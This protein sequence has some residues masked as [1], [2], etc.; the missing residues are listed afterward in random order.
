MSETKKYNW[1]NFVSFCLMAFLSGATIGISGT[2]FLL[3]NNLYGAWGRLIGGALFSLGIFFIVTYEKKLFTGMVA[4]LPRMKRNELWK[5]PICLL[6]NTIGVAI[7]ATL[8]AYTPI[9]ETV[10]AQGKL[11]IAAKLAADDWY[12]RVLCSSFLCG[13]LITMSVWSTEYAAK[14][15]LS[16]SVGVMF[17]IMLFAFCGFD[18]SIANMLYFCYLG[19]ASWKMFG[20]IL[21]SVCGNVLG[22]VVM[23][24]IMIVKEKAKNQ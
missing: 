6:F 1:K 23:P 15:G 9:G 21:I 13:M 17:P 7:V 18:H 20:Y 10:V 4:N 14:K 24:L 11:T 5:L 8:A 19:E 3:A 12:L 2:A 22:G 16:A